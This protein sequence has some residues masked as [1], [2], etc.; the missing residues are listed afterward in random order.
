MVPLPLPHYY[1]LPRVK[2]APSEKAAQVQTAFAFVLYFLQGFCTVFP[3]NLHSLSAPLLRESG[4][5]SVG[6]LRERR[7]ST[8]GEAK[9]AEGK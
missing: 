5:R 4:D 2:A 1:Y 7:K 9:D 3:P 8:K 6:S